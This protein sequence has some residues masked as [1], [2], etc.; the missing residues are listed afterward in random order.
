[1]AAKFGIE[2]GLLL[3][4]VV[5]SVNAA[6]LGD[7]VTSELGSLHYPT[8]VAVLVGCRIR[9]E[10]AISDQGVRAKGA[11]VGRKTE[12]HWKRMK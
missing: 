7:G 8:I 6:P 3:V 5:V 4:H 12:L 11:R 9:K 1:V 10:W 2:D